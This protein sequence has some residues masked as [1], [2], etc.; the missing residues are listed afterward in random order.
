MILHNSKDSSQS[1]SNKKN[2]RAT[3]NV[4]KSDREEYI[5]KAIPRIVARKAAVLNLQEALIEL[6]KEW[7]ILENIR[8]IFPNEWL[9]LVRQFKRNNKEGEIMPWS[10]PPADLKKRK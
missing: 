2:E 7:W 8:E 5:D 10:L 6:V 9:E 4:L 1:S 3:I